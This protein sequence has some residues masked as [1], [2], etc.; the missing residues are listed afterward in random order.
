MN[1]TLCGYAI[2]NGGESFRLLEHYINAFSVKDWNDI[3][4]K[5]SQLF[6]PWMKSAASHRLDGLPFVAAIDVKGIEIRVSVMI[7]HED[8]YNGLRLQL[9][10]NGKVLLWSDDGNVFYDRERK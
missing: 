6:M 3:L 10:S 1:T 8:W 4:D 5:L 7:D 2:I 9:E